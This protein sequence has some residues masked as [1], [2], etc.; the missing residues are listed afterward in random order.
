MMNQ[1]SH[2]AIQLI[3]LI[4]EYLDFLTNL[5]LC[6]L[7]RET[8]RHIFIKNIYHPRMT[9]LTLE[10]KKYQRAT[11]LDALMNMAI[12]WINHLKKLEVLYIK[13]YSG[14]DAEALRGLN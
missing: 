2:I 4:G 1:M 12:T 6:R 11:K 10:Q 13:E 9:D 3:Q 8:N 5:R 7:N 14:I